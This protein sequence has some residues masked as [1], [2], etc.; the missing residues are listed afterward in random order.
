MLEP[1]ILDRR[2]G[3]CSRGEGVEEVEEGEGAQGREG[4]EEGG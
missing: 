1:D 4:L 2:R 3:E